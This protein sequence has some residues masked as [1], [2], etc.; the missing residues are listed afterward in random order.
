MPQ[1]FH[2]QYDPECQHDNAND[3]VVETWAVSC[4]EEPTI[5]GMGVIVEVCL[6]GIAMIVS[7]WIEVLVV[8]GLGQFIFCVL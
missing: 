8:H 6:V 7:W 3:G 1:N 4:G 2:N 5:A